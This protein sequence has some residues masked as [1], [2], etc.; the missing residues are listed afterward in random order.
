MNKVVTGIAGAIGVA[1]VITAVVA[2]NMITGTQASASAAKVS[3]LPES[4]TVK[5][6]ETFD[7]TFSLST[8]AT[9]ADAGFS[10][11][12]ITL[13]FD[14]GNK[15]IIDLLGETEGGKFQITGTNM[16]VLKDVVRGT[17]TSG[18]FATF[19]VAVPP[20]TA[21]LQKTAT[22]TLTFK[23]L[24]PGS[25]QISIDTTKSEVSGNTGQSDLTFAL[26]QNKAM[27]ITS[28]S[29]EPSGNY[30]SSATVS[31]S[32][33]MQGGTVTSTVSVTAGTSITGIIDVEIFDAQNQ[34]VY[35]K[36][37]ADQQMTAGQKVTVS[38]PWNVG[39]ATKG[40][41]TVKV[42]IFSNDWKTLYN[43]NDAAATFTVGDTV[44]LAPTKAVT[45]QPTAKPTSKP[46]A[47]KTP[48]PTRRPT[49]TKVPSATAVPT[50]TVAP[51]AVPTTI[52]G[53][54]AFVKGVN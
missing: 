1:A 32:T 41:Y 3:F 38:V 53:S 27:T 54:G 49:A 29:T 44:T 51:S 2:T 28:N 20:E 16:T 21:T 10:A 25:S 11:A 26:E 22:F 40:T 15:G 50:A 19:T 46:P 37:F 33:V 30:S 23:S 52:S 42:G 17:D 48:R 12:Q 34:R 7:V 36:Y 8:S 13:R 18:K 35:Q 39:G 14:E 31:P 9:S 4:K 5:P 6:L 24:A 45:A 43:W 47:T